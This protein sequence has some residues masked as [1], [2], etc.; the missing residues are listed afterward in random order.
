LYLKRLA[1]NH[2]NIP[3]IIEH[4]DESDIPRAKIFVD[5]TLKKEGV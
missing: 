3:I 5:D 4:I 1:K 2:P